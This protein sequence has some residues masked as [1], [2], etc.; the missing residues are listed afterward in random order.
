MFKK[1]PKPLSSLLPLTEADVTVAAFKKDVQDAADKHGVDCYV[2]LM[3][4]FALNDKGERGS[5]MSR[6]STGPELQVIGLMSW[7]YG[8]HRGRVEQ[9]LNHLKQQGMNQGSK[10]G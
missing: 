7:A 9:I 10:Q 1:K 2:L 5:W 3:E 6:I 4:F 8:E